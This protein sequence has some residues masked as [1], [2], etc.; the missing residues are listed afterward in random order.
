MIRCPH[1][2]FDLVQLDLLPDNCPQCGR[3]LSSR[4]GV[5]PVDRTVSDTGDADR[6]ESQPTI[7]SVASADS[8]RSDAAA[9]G[10]ATVASDEWSDPIAKTVQSEEGSAL[11][12]EAAEAVR[13][14]QENDQTVASDEWAPESVAQTVQSDEF[15]SS[16]PAGGSSQIEAAQTVES[17]EA[18]DPALSQTVHSNEFSLQESPA[19]ASDDKT[20]AADD[21]SVPESGHTLLTEELDQQEIKTM[22]T[23]WSGGLHQGTNPHMTIK[24]LTRG[25]G[26]AGS[27]LVIKSRQLASPGEKAPKGREAEYE[28][29]RVLGE[30]GMGIVY[31]ARQ[32]SVDR[33]V[34]VKMLKPK[35]AGDDRQR[36]KFLAEAVVTGDLDHPN[37]VPIYDV[38]SSERGLLFYA[39]KKVK[40]TPWMKLLP[41]KSLAENLEILMK[42]ADAVGFA[43]SRG[44]IHRDLKP[45]NVMLGDYGEVLVMDWG[46]ALPAPGFTKS[47]TI[48]PAHSMGG[49]PAYM[50][51]EMASGP[52]EKISFVSDVYLL[53]AILYEILTGRPPHSGKNT[54]QCLF[55]AAK[56]DIRPTEKTG[57]LVEIA[58]KAMATDLAERYSDVKSFQDAIRE[59][60]SHTE[61][62]VLSGRAADEME[63]AA[64]SDDYRDFARAM[65][66]FEE[67]LSLWDGNGKAKNGLNVVR[68]KY[69]DS[70]LRKGDFDLG[71]SLLDSA[72]PDHGPLLR[73]L[74]DSQR[75]REARQ[76]RLQRMKRFAATAVALFVV[77]VSAAAYL[78]N[79]QKNRAVLAEIDAT[80]QR[81]AAIQAQEQEAVAK[82]DAEAQRDRAVKAREQEEVAKKE[83]EKQRDRAS[84]AQAKAE[85]ERQKAVEAKEKEEYEAYIAQIGLAAAQIDENAFDSARRTLESCK[86]ELRNW[87]WGRLMYLCG[88]SVR[89]VTA[90]ARLDA[91]AFSPDGKSFATGGW[92]H[93]AEVWETASGKRLAAL[94]HGGSY[95]FAVAF[96]PDGAL[97]ATG[98][99][100]PSGNLRVYNARTGELVRVFAG[101]TDGVLS[102]AFSKNGKRLLTSSFDKTARVFDVATGRELLALQGHSWWVWSAA[103]SPDEKRILTASQDGSAILWEAD[104]G[105]QIAQFLGHRGPVYSAAFS[106]TE[107]LVATAGYDNRILLWNP[108]AL[109]SFDF[110]KLA[111]GE[112][113]ELPPMQ[114]LEGHSAGVHSV[115]FSHDGALVISGSHDNTV[116]A[117]DVATRKP[118]K[119]FR[120]HGGW[121]QGCAI[122]PDGKLVLS[123]GHDETAR[124]WSL[125]DYEEIRVLHGRV[126][127]GHDDAV[128]AASFSRD[129]EQIVTASRDRT[130]RTWKVRTGAEL[131]T[132]AEG[133]QFLASNAVFSPDGKRLLTS[134]VDNTVRV[135]DVASGTETMKLEHTGRSAAMALSHDGKKLLTGS[136][137]AREDKRRPAK[138]WEMATGRLLKTLSEHTTEVTAVAFSPDDAVLFTG[139]AGGS[140]ILWDAATGE[141]LKRL[142]S[143]T[144]KITA[145]AFLA[146]GARLLT[147]SN[148][149]TVAQWDVK[150]GKEIVP[151]VLKHGEA[152]LS[153]AL[154]PTTRQALSS[155]ADGQVRLWDLD[156]ATTTATL[157]MRAVIHSV[158]VSSDGA[159]ALTVDAVERTVRLWDLRAGREREF[160]KPGKKGGAFLDFRG[161]RGLL[162]TAEFAPDREGILTVG[163]T[164]ARLWNLE[165]G[166]ERISFSPHGI[167][168]SA[169]FSPDGERVV[170]ASWDNSARVW[171]AK[172]G[173]ALL[174]LE[175]QHT[176]PVNAAMYSP[177]GSLIL[178][179]GDDQLAVLW[180]ASSG[181]VVQVLKGHEAGIRAAC[182]APDGK[183]LLT[184]STDKTARLWDVATGSALA[185]LKGHDW[186]VLSVAF[187][188]DGSRIITGSEDNTARIWDKSGKLLLTLAGHSAPVS[189]V[190]YLPDAKANRAITGSLDGTAKLWDAQTGKEILTL[191]GHSQEVTCVNASPVGR[192]LL[193]GSRDGTAVVW[194]A[195]DWTAPDADGAPKVAG[196]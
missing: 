148:D 81:D 79:V 74:G 56:N 91:V 151:L 84:L 95:V 26:G 147:A 173:K 34:A 149:H 60:Q 141:V 120:G 50:A 122:S 195:V 177:D 85:E 76:Q 169:G 71:A 57:E 126:L 189:S 104:S 19:A 115:V 25:A 93:A 63:R 170:T 138:L 17:H 129:G 142:N 182:F 11:F 22:Q 1:C 72:N 99:N 157:P 46:L 82:K 51:P 49:T 184:G 125:P 87:E 16:G 47:S 154:L 160:P 168:A 145:A 3:S 61:S 94:P 192:Y 191:K 69:A 38:G 48:S 97:V 188:A 54:M 113:I 121:V 140:G 75:E 163:G 143:H 12:D 164:D 89:T 155:C 44:V 86:P 110:R 187:C 52:L 77:A 10:G 105:K 162:W 172:S 102:V 67:A 68:L 35:T 185:V 112:Q 28:L 36:Q 108:D 13:A 153:L 4:G 106:P 178:T 166:E 150:T 186:S 111:A 21:W 70:A 64:Q 39:M 14:S 137:Y 43:H 165:T 83:A 107:S 146:D 66:G 73:K 40:G 158:D 183:R 9:E 127:E 65:F 15:T 109:R 100:D 101:H 116:K 24:G 23:L 118:L 193:T 180:N 55:A 78:I 114:A 152:V 171:D 174:K 132:F 88:Q 5:S 33:S 45:E 42:V 190:A 29:I 194:L 124:L 179:A 128:L 156:K 27:T 53:G 32:T 159:L 144:G 117:W 167:V 20:I 175:H 134:A 139:D 37:I 98:S 176:K 123:A 2:Q 90:Q 58:R 130:A 30:G 161:R 8:H 136:D 131:Q 80:N 119:T 135:W 103:F 41:E 59:Y 96:S 133:H 62:I 18:D 7:D 6:P 196:E 92:N 181:A 31:D